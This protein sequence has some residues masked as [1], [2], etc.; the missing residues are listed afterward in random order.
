[1]DHPFP[2]SSESSWIR[3]LRHFPDTLAVRVLS[4]TYLKL[5]NVQIKCFPLC[6]CVQ[7]HCHGNSGIFWE[8]KG[9]KTVWLISHVEGVVCRG[10]LVLKVYQSNSSKFWNLLRNVNCCWSILCLVCSVSV[11]HPLVI[12]PNC[13]KLSTTLAI[14]SLHSESSISNIH[15][16][17]ISLNQPQARH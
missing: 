13:P 5:P 14:Q 17:N 16:T 6:Y 7:K 1:M 8:Y 3:N 2:S 15:Q 11:G 10:T 4:V 12:G 9:T